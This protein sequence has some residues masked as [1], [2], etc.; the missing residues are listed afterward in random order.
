MRT[1]SCSANSIEPGQ[2]AL[3]AKIN[4][5]RFQQN[6]QQQ[7]SKQWCLMFI[8]K[9][10]VHCLIL[11]FIP[12]TIWLFKWVTLPNYF[13]IA[14]KTILVY[15]LPYTFYNHNLPIQIRRCSYGLQTAKFYLK[16]KKQRQPLYHKPPCS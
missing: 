6:K 11:P 4:Y 9:Y 8:D 14:D 16:K 3:E 12:F 1:W 10:I 13:I 2:T 7:T 15:F 5:V